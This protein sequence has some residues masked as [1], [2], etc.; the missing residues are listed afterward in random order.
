MILVLILIYSDRFDYNQKRIEDTPKYFCKKTSDSG[1][2]FVEV[3]TKDK[4]WYFGQVDAY[5]YPNGIGVKMCSNGSFIEGEWC[6]GLVIRW[7]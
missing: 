4:E 2:K 7:R 1:S 6:H 5:K 3:I